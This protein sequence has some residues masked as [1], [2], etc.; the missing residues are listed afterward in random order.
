L[1]LNDEKIYSDLDNN[2]AFFN[3]ALIN[4][5]NG[6]AYEFSRQVSYY[7][8]SDSDGS[9]SEGKARDSVV[10][11]S[12]PPGRYY[13]RVEPEMDT[14]NAQVRPNAVSYQ[15]HITH[16]VTT[17][18]YFFIACLLM[19]IPPIWTTL[20]SGSFETRRWAESDYGASTTSTTSGDDD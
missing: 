5:D 13:L 20:R 15:I 4:A 19:L 10:L 7:R 1:V 6:K 3:L 12:I 2:W 17:W 8:G 9:W 11:P 16:D 14:T 18:A